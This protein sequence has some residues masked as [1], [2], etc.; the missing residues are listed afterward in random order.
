M[1]VFI[2]LAAAYAV[3]ILWLCA[4]ILEKAGIGKIWTLTLLIPI[5]NLV[6]IW[7]FAFSEW[8]SQKNGSRS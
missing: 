3:F 1:E 8:P 7:I 5:V 6:L 2:L 4:R